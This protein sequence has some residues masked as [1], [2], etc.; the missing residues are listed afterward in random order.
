MRGPAGCQGSAGPLT[1]P[2][3]LRSSV[4]KAWP[5]WFETRLSG[6]PEISPLERAWVTTCVAPPCGSVGDLQRQLLRRLD[7]AA[8][9]LSRSAPGAPAC[10]S[11]WP[12]AIASASFSG[13]RY[14]SSRTVS[15]PT[16]RRSSAYSLP[17]PFTRMLVG[18]VGQFAAGASGSMPVFLASSLRPFGVLAASSNVAVVL[19]PAAFRLRCRR[20]CLRGS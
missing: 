6:L 7:P 16:A 12:R 15:T 11:R 10:A 18:L 5:H 13:L 14:F 1:H 9:G 2:E 20:R 4:S 8:D 17:R 19:M 3:E